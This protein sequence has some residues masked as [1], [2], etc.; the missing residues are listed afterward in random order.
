MPVGSASMLTPR[1][2]GEPTGSGPAVAPVGPTKLFLDGGERCAL[3]F[4]LRQVVQAAATT[5]RR[6]IGGG[7]LAAV[8][9]ASQQSGFRRGP[10][11]LLHQGILFWEQDALDSV[12]RTAAARGFQVAQHAIG[13]EAISVGL[14]AIERAGD[15]LDRLPGRPRLEHGMFI[16]PTYLSICRDSV[17]HHVRSGRI[18][19]PFVI[20]AVITPSNPTDSSRTRAQD[21]AR[22]R[23]S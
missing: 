7:G 5:L 19:G 23:Q 2:D 11:G 13:N 14:T 3:C 10:D 16:D 17:R 20:T 15:A 12:V 8:R 9:A 6:A 22:R 4:S 1:F 21:T 18:G